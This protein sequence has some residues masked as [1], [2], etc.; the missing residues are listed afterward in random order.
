VMFAV[1]NAFTSA[2]QSSVRPMPQSPIADKWVAGPTVTDMGATLQVIGTADAGTRDEALANS[3]ESA[4]FRAA[5]ELVRRQSSQNNA[6]PLSIS[7][8]TLRAYIK[9]VGKVQ[10][11][12]AQPMS[13]GYRG[14]TKLIVSRGLLDPVTIRYLAVPSV[15]AS[16][17]RAIGYLLLPGDV[18]LVPST[19]YR[20]QAVCAKS[21]D[22]N[23][24]LFFAPLPSRGKDR[25]LRLDRIDVLDD[26]S[27]AAT[28]WAFEVMMNGSR[29]VR[30]A[31]ATYDDRV[32]RYRMPV[33]DSTLELSLSDDAPT[34]ELQV[35]GTR[36]Q[37][38]S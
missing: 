35:V 6:A 2:A 18:K 1:G 32:G 5:T 22:G 20:V 25:R 17:R 28:Q 29:V 30:V 19:P 36:P 16:S 13:R 31:P 23:F 26:G 9:R 10:D 34:I 4:T 11:T 38:G 27:G 8:D 14:Y 15:K 21:S 7:F 12:Y 24:I 3:L 33:G 37:S